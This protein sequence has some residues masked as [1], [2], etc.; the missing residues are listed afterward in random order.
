MRYDAVSFIIIGLLLM[1]FSP[2]IVDKWTDYIDYRGD[3]YYFDYI[4]RSIIVIMIG[5]GSFISGMFLFIKY[6]YSNN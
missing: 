1:I 4:V 6:Y 2:N 5:F 3:I